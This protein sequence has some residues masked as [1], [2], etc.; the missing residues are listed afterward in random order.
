MS[1]VLKARGIARRKDPDEGEPRE[2]ADGIVP[3]AFVADRPD[4]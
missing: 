3:A 1:P 2:V 4:C